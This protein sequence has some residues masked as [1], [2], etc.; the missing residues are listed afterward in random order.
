MY[1]LGNVKTLSFLKSGLHVSIGLQMDFEFRH[2]SPSQI[3]HT[4]LFSGLEFDPTHDEDFA[5][6]MYQTD[7]YIVG[8]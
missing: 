7:K 5:Y 8:V 6:E 4:L 2:V 3:C 1:V